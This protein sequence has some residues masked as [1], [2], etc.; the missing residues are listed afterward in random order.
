VIPVREER[1]QP[2]PHGQLGHVLSCNHVGRVSEHDDGL[3]LRSSHGREGFFEI[4][5]GPRDDRLQLQS[6]LTGR[7]LQRLES[8]RV[9]GDVRVAEKRDSLDLRDN[10]D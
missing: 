6:Q 9:G 5:R 7:L 4:G 3:R 8:R 2:V 10:S 1:G